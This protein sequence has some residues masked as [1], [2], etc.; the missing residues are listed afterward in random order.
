MYHNVVTYEI[1]VKFSFSC[2]ERIYFGLSLH[3]GSAQ[4]THEILIHS[5]G[6]IGIAGHILLYGQD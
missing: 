6:G 1:K 2:M 3:G 5:C 4:P